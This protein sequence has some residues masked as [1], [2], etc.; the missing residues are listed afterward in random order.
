MKTKLRIAIAACIGLIAAA[1]AGENEKS[2][3]PHKL[4]PEMIAK[5]DK[6]G[7]GKLNNEERA[8]AKAARKEMMLEKFDTNKDGTLDETEKAAMKGA[9]KKMILEKFD[10][11]QDGK[12][13]DIEKAAMREKVKN[14]F[15]GL[16]GRQGERKGGGKKAGDE[17]APGALE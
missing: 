1:H 2:R 11:D 10:K 17:E 9:R 13:N 16:R 15:S 14:R 7:D 6:D 3:Q 12:L 5:F 8:A 4:A